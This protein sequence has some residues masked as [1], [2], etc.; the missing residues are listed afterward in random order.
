M[1]VFP[2]Y[3]PALLGTVFLA[4]RKRFVPALVFLLALAW[5]LAFFAKYDWY[6]DDFC[7]PIYFLC[8]APLAA[9]LGGLFPPAQ[10]EPETSPRAW[11]L[12]LA[13]AVA[14]L[15]IVGLGRGAIAAAHRGPYTLVGDISHA[16]VYLGDIPCDYFNNQVDRWECSSFDRGSEWLM[17]GVTLDG[18][19]VFNGER[20]RM[21]SISPHPQRQPRR[22]VFHVP[23]GHGFKLWHGIP[24][25]AP[26]GVPVDLTILLD[27][28][29]AGHEVDD[30]PGLRQLDLDTQKLA[31]SVHTLEI[32]VTG[33]ASQARWFYVDGAVTG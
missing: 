20:R 8:A 26:A 29:P 25:G 22:I 7:D 1:T 18:E 32:D 10:G 15:L 5:P 13:A 11:R 14:A 17:T 28:Q 27:G 33:P 3:L 19:P 2:L 31:G 23:M 12:G 9:W 6:R 30:G 4:S 24:D 16:D 21:I